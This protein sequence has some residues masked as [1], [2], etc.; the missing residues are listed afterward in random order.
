MCISCS[1]L[2]K[3]KLVAG[4]V[5]MGYHY[6]GQFQVDN[7]GYKEDSKAQCLFQGRDLQWNPF[8]PEIQRQL[9]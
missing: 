3:T 4:F 2:N 5:E 9:S 8:G 7:R 1:S 6:L